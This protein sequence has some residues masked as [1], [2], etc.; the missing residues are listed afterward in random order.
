MLHHAGEFVLFKGGK[1]VEFFPSYERAYAE[2]LERFG[3]K[4]EFLVQRVARE[5][6]DPVNLAWMHGVAFGKR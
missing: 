3:A 1:P 6:P 2:G 4:L 5:A